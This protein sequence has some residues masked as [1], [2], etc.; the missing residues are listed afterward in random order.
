VLAPTGR[1]EATALDLLNAV[2]AEPGNQATRTTRTAWLALPET[3]RAGLLARVTVLARQATAR[4]LA[5][6][7]RE[8]LMMALPRAGA[9]AFLDVLLGWWW[10]VSVR[11][12]S[13]EIRGVTRVELR[14]VIADLQERFSTRSLPM[15]VGYDG[16]PTS[17]DDDRD[18]VFA[19]QLMWIE[20]GENLLFMA[21][22]DYYRTY[23]Q[24]QVWVEQHMV[25]LDELHDYEQR[26]VREWDVQYELMRLGLGDGASATAMRDA[27]L[28]LYALALNQPPGLLRPGLTDP[29]YARGTHHRLADEGHV[30]WHPEFR[31]RL[32]ALLEGRV[33]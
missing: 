4:E 1:S 20:A 21:V 28:R 31:R 32:E 19:H 14:L 10:R 23:A 17:A 24:Q 5:T 30:G 13:G 3:D 22:Q 26:L 29:F 27:G 2:A 9:E 18:R 6:E 33:A 15:T 8:V 11:M 12:L 7:L 25:G 16:L